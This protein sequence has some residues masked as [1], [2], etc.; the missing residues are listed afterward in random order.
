[1]CNICGAGNFFAAKTIAFYAAWGY[2][3]ACGRHS[4]IPPLTR[5]T[6]A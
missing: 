2:S 1:M 6:N 5:H 3:P 4:R